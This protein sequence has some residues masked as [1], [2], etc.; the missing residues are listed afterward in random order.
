MVGCVS[1]T[2]DFGMNGKNYGTIKRSF[3]LL[4][5]MEQCGGNSNEM[6]RTIFLRSLF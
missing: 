1:I 3:L 6:V 4:L 2:G 5:L